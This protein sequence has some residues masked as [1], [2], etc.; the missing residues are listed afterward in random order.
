MKP[1]PFC[2]HEVDLED[3]DTLYPAGIG[4]KDNKM[5]QLFLYRDDMNEIYVWMDVVTLEDVSPHFDYE[6]DADTWY[7][8]QNVLVEIV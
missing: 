7:Q 6:E 2:G 1:C 8:L 5:N 3:E 4:W